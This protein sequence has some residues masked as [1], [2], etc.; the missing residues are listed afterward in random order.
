M[1]MS[2]FSKLSAVCLLLF[3]SLL[4]ADPVVPPVDTD[5]DNAASAGPT[6]SDAGKR[7][8][9]SR[10]MICHS[11]L[12]PF[13]D[14]V[15]RVVNWYSTIDECLSAN[16]GARLPMSKEGK[17][18]Q[19]DIAKDELDTLKKK[20]VGDAGQGVAQWAE[21]IADKKG[22]SA[23]KQKA[24]SDITHFTGLRFGYGLALTKSNS[25]FVDEVEIRNGQAF[26][27][28]A[29]SNR[30][31]F[32]LEAHKFFQPNRYITLMCNEELGCNNV[33]I[34]PFVAVS[35]ANTEG[36]DPFTSYALGIMFGFKDNVGSGSFNVG[37]GYYVDTEHVELAPGIYHGAPTTETDP[38]SLVVESDEGGLAIIVSGSW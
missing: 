17:L 3:S 6:A 20:I 15:T 32:M 2:W 16:E 27:K 9:L 13:Y 19:A 36:G 30:G 11:P 33:G 26:I 35:L 12:S 29:R 34:G 23:S 31:S 38:D 25:D 7:I 5:A 22:E 10:S 4:Y 21:E 37:L 1:K 18:E 8:K 24:A 14:R 28:K